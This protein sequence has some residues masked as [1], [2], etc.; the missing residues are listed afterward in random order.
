MVFDPENMKR[1][2]QFLVFGALAAAVGCV[3][4]LSGPDTAQA[5]LAEGI[6]RGGDYVAGN[7]A[8]NPS[9]P[10][11]LL[12]WGAGALTAV[13]GTAKGSAV[14]AARKVNA[15]RDEARKVRGEAV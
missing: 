13:A 11:E 10:L 9:N 1:A 14:M 5:R 4:P 12:L 6:H 8:P 15:S 2:T 7:P 3:A